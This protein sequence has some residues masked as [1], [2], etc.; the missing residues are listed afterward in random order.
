MPLRWCS[1]LIP[2]VCCMPLAAS[3]FVCRQAGHAP[4]RAASPKYRDASVRREDVRQRLDEDAWDV[5]ARAVGFPLLRGRC[6]QYRF[7]GR[8]HGSNGGRRRVADRVHPAGFDLLDWKASSP[9]VLSGELCEAAGRLAASF[10][11][12]CTGLIRPGAR[13][14]ASGCP[15]RRC[16]GV[17]HSRRGGPHPAFER[18]VCRL[19]D[20]A[21][22]MRCLGG[23]R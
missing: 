22:T 8:G 14:R 12:L 3:F 5:V 11:S 20:D 2:L 23:G 1:A 10:A 21:S 9:V 19:H 4:H 6:T 16:R 15:S 13:R 17:V 18:A 7:A